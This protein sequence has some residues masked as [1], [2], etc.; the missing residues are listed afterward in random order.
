VQFNAF[1]ATATKKIQ[2]EYDKQDEL[3]QGALDND[4]TSE[5]ASQAS[6]AAPPVQQQG[7]PLS[8]SMAAR[9]E[10]DKQCTSC[11]I[12]LT[13][14]DIESKIVCDVCVFKGP[15]CADHRIHDPNTNVWYCQEHQGL[16]HN[17]SSQAV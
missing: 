13:P 16:I 1:P 10:M 17:N 5:A 8:L 2:A 4:D 12:A 14:A 3:A 7:P 11:G 15:L 6:A 9:P